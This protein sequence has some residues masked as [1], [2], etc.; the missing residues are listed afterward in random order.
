MFLRAE[1][2]KRNRYKK[3]TKHFPGLVSSSACLILKPNMGKGHQHILLSS[4]LYSSLFFPI[5]AIF[6][7]R[8]YSLFGLPRTQTPSD[9][10]SPIF[11]MGIDRILSPQWLNRDHVA[12]GAGVFPRPANEGSL[13]RG[14]SEAWNSLAEEQVN[15]ERTRLR[16][17]EK[18]GQRLTL[19]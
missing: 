17:G 14:K 12:A 16:H 9:S 6:S 18:Q 2:C 1:I 19:M 8:Q 11:F 5:L 15:K 7:Q 13:H 3:R 4:T 10:S